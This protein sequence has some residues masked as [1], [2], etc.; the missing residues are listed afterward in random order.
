MSFYVAFALNIF[1][2][3]KWKKQILQRFA[4]LQEI[5]DFLFGHEITDAQR[6][7]ALD[8]AVA[9][10]LHRGDPR[11]SF[12]FIDPETMVNHTSDMELI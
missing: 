4:A 12:E 7:Q 3:F 1:S 9:E 6:Q 5:M 8:A 11:A 2:A 10:D